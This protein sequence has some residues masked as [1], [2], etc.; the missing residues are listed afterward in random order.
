MVDLEWM[1]VIRVDQPWPAEGYVREAVIPAVVE[2]RRRSSGGRI[3]PT[4]IWV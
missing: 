3:K 1:P 2:G 4:S